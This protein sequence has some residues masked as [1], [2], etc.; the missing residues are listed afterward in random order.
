MG[1]IIFLGFITIIFID[2]VPLIKKKQKGEIITFSVFFVLSLVIV[3]LIL[4]EIEIP[5]IMLLLDEVL[6]SVGLSY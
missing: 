4:Q 6:K 1:F 3:I 2:F 5:S